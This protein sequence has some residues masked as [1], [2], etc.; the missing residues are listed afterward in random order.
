MSSAVLLSKEKHAEIS[1]FLLNTLLN[2]N[3]LD[4]RFGW[5]E[6]LNLFIL[7]LS[8]MCL[9]EQIEFISVN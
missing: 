8:G 6:P 9:D 7:L 2:K 1:S 3:I 4:A 5:G